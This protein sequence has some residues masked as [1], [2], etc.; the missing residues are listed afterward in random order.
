MLQQ[1]H[2]EHLQSFERIE[3]QKY[4]CD[5]CVKQVTDGYILEPARLVELPYA[6]T[7]LLTNMPQSMPVVTHILW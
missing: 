1:K 3:P 4:Q 7:H 2:G 6:A 5:E